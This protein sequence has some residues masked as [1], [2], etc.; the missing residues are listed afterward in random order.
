MK[1]C[2]V[3]ET[4][5]PLEGFHRNK[6]RLD[7]YQSYCKTCAALRNRAYYVA[8]P[9]KQVERKANRT[10]AVLKGKKLVDDH[11]SKNFCVDCGNSD[12]RVLEF[13]HVRGIKIGNVSQMVTDGRGLEVIVAEIAK[14]EVRCAN[15]HR[16]V[17]WERR[18]NS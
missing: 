8:T 4:K 11:F 13:D 7:G 14:C 12:R 16:V 1:I 10:K 6:R 15:C 5:K 9:H 3:C 18:I 2:S 17:T